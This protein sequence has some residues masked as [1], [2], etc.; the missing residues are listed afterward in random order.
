[1]NEKRSYRDKLLGEIAGAF[2]RA[3]DVGHNMEMEVD[4]D[5]EFSDLPL[6]EKA[7]KLSGTTKSR[8]RAQRSNAVILKVVG[9]STGYSF[10][11]SRIVSMWKPSGRMDCVNLGQDFFLVRFAEKVD[12]DRVLKGGPWFVGGH[13]L[14]IRQW[15]P[16]FKASHA[17]LSSVAVWIQLPELPIEYYE[18]SV[19]QEIG[20]VIGPVLRIDTHTAAE[21]RG[22]FARLCVQINLDE[23]ITKLLKLGGIDQ[24]VQYEGL[25]SLCFAC[26]RVGHKMENCHYKVVASATEE[27]KEAAGNGTDVQDQTS[28]EEKV[29]GPWVLVSRKKP[30]NRQ[31]AKVLVHNSSLGYSGRSPRNQQGLTSLD[32]TLGQA[33]VYDDSSD[34]KGQITDNAG[35]SASPADRI[36]ASQNKDISYPVTNTLSV[37]NSDPRK[38]AKNKT[39]DA[40]RTKITSNKSFLSWKAVGSNPFDPKLGEGSRSFSSGTQPMISPSEVHEFKAGGSASAMELLN[41]QTHV[42]ELGE[43]PITKRDLVLSEEGLISVPNQGVMSIKASNSESPKFPNST[44]LE[45]KQDTNFDRV[46]SSI[47]SLPLKRIDP[48]RRSKGSGNGED[49]VQSMLTDLSKEQRGCLDSPTDEMLVEERGGC[50]ILS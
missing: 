49:G 35:V 46:S 1:M 39:R 40:P 34:R 20:E 42:K 10:L 36:K 16:N 32:V 14:S 23:P 11:H 37:K 28:K 38:K 21:S 5:D 18:P 7:V 41:R 15:E 12:L 17:N 50:P 44:P 45:G 29:F 31:G 25:S 30:P 47:S 8:I 27:G 3:F 26:G 24:P 33:E 13:Y 43:F 48:S 19:F 4:S 9:K 2:E 22:R 6:G